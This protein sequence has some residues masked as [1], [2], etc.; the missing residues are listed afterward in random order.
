MLILAHRAYRNGID[1]SRENRLEAVQD[2]L[3]D[4]F[5][6]ETDIRRDP[7]LGFYISHDPATGDIVKRQSASAFCRAIRES[8]GP[9]I[10][11]NVK[12]LGYEADLLTFLSDEG[13]VDRL[14]LFDM[15]L[16][17]NERGRTAR[18][19]RALHS[20]HPHC[21]AHQRPRRSP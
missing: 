20:D 18:T 8:A 17:E 6:V 1:P 14:F 4:G 7:A 10:A 21:R 3:R 13:I 9:P 12:E 19:L 5:G 11:L 16:L 2:C 15:E